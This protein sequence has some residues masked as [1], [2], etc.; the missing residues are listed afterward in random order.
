MNKMHTHI[1]KSVFFFCIHLHVYWFL[2]TTVY[3]MA[4]NFSFPQV[5][6]VGQEACSLTQH[7]LGFSGERTDCSSLTERNRGPAG[8]GSVLLENSERDGSEPC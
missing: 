4:T 5:H 8:T 3:I 7:N 6:P 2:R 1:C